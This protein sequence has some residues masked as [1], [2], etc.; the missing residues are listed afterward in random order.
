MGSPTLNVYEQLGGAPVADRIFFDLVDRFYD[1]LRADPV[2]GGMFPVDEQE[3]ALAKRHQALFLLQ[4]FGGPPQYGVE[5]GHPRLRMRH[6]P[7]PIDEAARDAW[8][9]HMRAELE[10]TAAF[11]AEARLEMMTYFENAAT[12]MRNR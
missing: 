2:V 4:F 1:R 5:R 9:G 7:F 10:A 12:F 11:S 3:F 6:Q 8:V